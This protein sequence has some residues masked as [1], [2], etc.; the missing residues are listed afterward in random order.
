MR[1]GASL[2]ASPP[3]VACHRSLLEAPRWLDPSLGRSPL[4]AVW[5]KAVRFRP[6]GAA[7][8][9]RGGVW[10]NLAP[11]TTTAAW[12][13]GVQRIWPP[14]TAVTTWKKGGSGGS[15]PHA[16]PPLSGG[17]S[18]VDATPARHREAEAVRSQ[19]RTPPLPRGRRGA[20]RIRPPPS[21][22]V[23][24]SA[25]LRKGAERIWPPHAA[26]R[27]VRDGQRR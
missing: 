11:R 13:K 10:V 16:P 19:L 21:P 3:H 4:A 6:C 26:V 1:A 17:G 12:K 27:R 25:T 14:R 18:R 15:V 8:P 5:K 24:P 2:D 22:H 9:S 23:L 20:D 7:S